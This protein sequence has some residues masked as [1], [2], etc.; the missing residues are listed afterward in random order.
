MSCVEVGVGDIGRNFVLYLFLDVHFG[1]TL[2]RKD[3]AVFYPSFVG[4]A[5]QGFD[6]LDLWGCGAKLTLGVP[7]ECLVFCLLLL[8]VLK[9]F[10]LDRQNFLERK[11]HSLIV[12][13]TSVGDRTIHVI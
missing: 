3:G 11:L 7:L 6:S 4:L 1:T 5:Q 8:D 12:G 9:K 10:L 13:L 2:S